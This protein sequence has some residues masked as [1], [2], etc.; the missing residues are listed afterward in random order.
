VRP[1]GGKNHEL[2]RLVEDGKENGDIVQVRAAAVGIVEEKHIARVDVTL[3]VL[4][5]T[6]DTPWQR[7]DVAGM[8]PPLGDELAVGPKQSAREVVHLIDDRG[9]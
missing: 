1:H 2:A 5:G 7:Q 3:E 9:V 6:A 8:I 4:E